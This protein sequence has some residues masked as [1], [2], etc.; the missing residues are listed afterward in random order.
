MVNRNFITLLLDADG[1][2]ETDMSARISDGKNRAKTDRPPWKYEPEW[3]TVV[4]YA[5]LT[6]CKMYSM[7]RLWYFWK[8]FL[9]KK[10]KNVFSV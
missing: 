8:F 9:T 1:K 3:C 2:S 4:I 7:L 5:P 10:L 6:S